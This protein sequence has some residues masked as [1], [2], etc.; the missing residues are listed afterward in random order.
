MAIAAFIGVPSVILVLLL[1]LWANN[2]GMFKR[3]IS[4]KTT[5]RSAKGVDKQTPVT[6]SGFV[7][8]N[9]TQVKLLEQD[10]IELTFRVEREHVDWIRRDST[11]TVAAVGSFI[12]TKEIKIDGGTKASPP[13]RDGDTLK[14]AESAEI[15]NIMDRVNPIIDTV[16]RITLRIDKVLGTFPNERLNSSVSD[17]SGIISDI[18]HGNATIGK[19]VSTDNGEL[20]SK[21]EKLLT[22]L[23]DISQK[24][25]DASRHL[26]ETMENVTEISRNV[27]T[28]S[29]DLPEMQKTLHQVLKNLNRAL[30]DISAMTPDI[31][32]TVKHV[33]DMAQDVSKATPAVPALM[34]DVELALSETL[35][36]IQSLKASWPV[37]NLVPKIKD[38]APFQP[39]QRQSP[40]HDAPVA[41]KIVPEPMPQPTPNDAGA[42]R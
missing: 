1:L 11:A 29:K 2:Q 9:V 41:P 8:G 5:T 3:M 33:G 18:K 23:N 6:F 14:A 10:N 13:V 21:V 39:T 25:D 31:R 16:E 15:A 28:G 4:L 22:K 30:D 17:I 32:K 34:D 37:K 36:M 24:V 40:Y 35:V 26:P 19:L 7:I 20:Y 12:G 42:A 38:Q 27:K